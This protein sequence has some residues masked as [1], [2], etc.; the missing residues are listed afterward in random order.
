[1]SELHSLTLRL[2]YKQFNLQF[3][4]NTFLTHYT[5]LDRVTWVSAL[6]KMITKVD[7]KTFQGSVYHDI[8]SPLF[9][10]KNEKTQRNKNQVL[11]K[12]SHTT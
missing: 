11:N 8:L 12:V 1:M 7:Q 5:P 10:D 4:T 6:P 3:Y 9:E 2:G